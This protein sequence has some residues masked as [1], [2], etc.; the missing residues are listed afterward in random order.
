[1][2][3]MTQFTKTK[4]KQLFWLLEFLAFL[5]RPQLSRLAVYS[6]KS[7]RKHYRGG[8][9]QKRSHRSSLKASLAA[10]KVADFSMLCSNTFIEMI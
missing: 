5:E 1:M 6:E 3:A 10:D 2:Q 4:P 9:P 8:G 7:H